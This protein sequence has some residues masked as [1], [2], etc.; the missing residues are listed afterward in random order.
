MAHSR[1]LTPDGAKVYSLWDSYVLADVVTY[2]STWEGWGNQYIEAVF[3]KLPVLIWEYP[4]WQ[5]DLGPAGFEVVSLGRELT[6][7]DAAGLVTVA[8]E[9]V[10]AAA[11]RVRE[12]GVAFRLPRGCDHLSWERDAEWN[13]YPA[14]HI[15]RPAGVTGPFPDL[16]AVQ[17]GP[18]EVPTWPWA[19]DATAAG[20]KDFR[21]TKRFI[22]RY[23][24]TAPGGAGL[25]VEADGDRHARAWVAGDH[26][27][28]QA[29]HF[30]GRSAES[31]IQGVDLAD[32]RLEKG[33]VIESEVVCR[34]R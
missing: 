11:F 16:R 18:W 25:E 23:A 31:F 30:T 22:R 17:A 8:P 24:L 10:L 20:C 9:K 26:I 2:P 21:G 3:A 6:G 13:W 28:M 27:G 34:I 29:G 14:D 1:G 33:T 4:V 5:T 12:L 7:K 32:L 15:G 19:H